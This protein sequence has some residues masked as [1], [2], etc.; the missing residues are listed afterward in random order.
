M[1]ANNFN[2]DAR[3]LSCIILSWDNFSRN[4]GFGIEKP[5]R[6]TIVREIKT[7]VEVFKSRPKELCRVLV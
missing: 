6:D 7:Q 3:L 5:M 1:A 2:E 4:K